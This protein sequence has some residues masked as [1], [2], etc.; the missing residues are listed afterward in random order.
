VTEIARNRIRADAQ[1]KLDPALV[2]RAAADL[3]TRVT[4]GAPRPVEN[5]TLER[6]D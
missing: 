2:R 3:D 1:A 5:R 6:G 4:A